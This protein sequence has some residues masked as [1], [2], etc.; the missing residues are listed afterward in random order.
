M[1]HF[2]PGAGERGPPGRAGV[3]RS[4]Q[5]HSPFQETQW[6][7]AVSLF[8]FRFLVHRKS[9]REAGRAGG[10]W[11]GPREEE[12]GGVEVPPESGA[13]GRLGRVRAP[14]PLVLALRS[15]PCPHCVIERSIVSAAWRSH[16]GLRAVPS[17]GSCFKGGLDGQ[18]CLEVSSKG[19]LLFPIS[20][21]NSFS[22]DL[23]FF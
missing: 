6:M 23:I 10:E 8:H 18:G 14:Q 16:A 12:G 22:G 11:A 15:L 2:R 1:R 21:N 9:E 3:P 13:S 5:V 17:C 19:H 7:A 20:K 4:S